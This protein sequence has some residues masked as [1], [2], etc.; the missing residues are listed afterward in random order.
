MLNLK[1]AEQ[2]RIVA[3]AL[4][5]GCKLGHHVAHELLSLFV[6]VIGVDEDVANVAVEVIANGANHQTGFLVNQESAFAAMCCAVDGRPQFK[7]VV[8]VPLQLGCATTNACGTGNDGHPFWIFQLVHGFFEFCAVVAFNS[9]AHTTTPWVVRHQD[10][11]AASQTDEGG[12]GSALVATLFFFN[13]HQEFL[14]FSNDIID[15]RL[16]NGNAFGKVLAGDFFEWQKAVT[17][18][19]VVDKAGL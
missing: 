19:A 17:L 15:A 10:H 14:A 7:Q 4:H 3:I 16:A 6:D 1:A 8:Q 5:A 11:I 18:F 12:E 9:A 13:L 2:R